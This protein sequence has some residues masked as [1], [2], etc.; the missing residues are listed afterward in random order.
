MNTSIVNKKPTVSSEKFKFVAL[1]LVAAIVRIVVV[2]VVVV[3]DIVVL[4]P[5]WWH[6]NLFC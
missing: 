5:F 6:F 1:L 4:A 3:L 2:A